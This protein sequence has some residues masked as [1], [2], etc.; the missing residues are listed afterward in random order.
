M[1]FSKG[2]TEKSCGWQNGGCEQLC[3]GTMH[4]FTC[5]CSNGMKL[6]PNGLDCMPGSLSNT[7]K[8]NKFI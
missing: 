8:L 2:D 6:S 4:G 1:F 3:F 7:Y 5:G